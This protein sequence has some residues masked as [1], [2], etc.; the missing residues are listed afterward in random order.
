MY[1]QLGC[2]GLYVKNITLLKLCTYFLTFFFQESS[3]DDDAEDLETKLREK[4]L[5]SMKK[6]Q[7]GR[8]D[9]DSEDESDSSD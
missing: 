9:E 8:R 7:K 3:S 2:S 4:A 5:Q 6:G 1:S